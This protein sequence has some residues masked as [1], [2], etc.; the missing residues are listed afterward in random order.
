MI[1]CIPKIWNLKGKIKVE[2]VEENIFKFVF[3]EIREKEDV[4]RRRPWS[5]NGSLLI[6]KEWSSGLQLREIVFNTSTFTV[7]IHGLPP[8][9]FN[10]ENA[11]K[12]GNM[13]GL[14]YKESLRLDFYRSSSQ[15]IP[16]IPRKLIPLESARDV[17]PVMDGEQLI[18]SDRY[19]AQEI[20]NGRNE[21]M[22]EARDVISVNPTVAALS[23]T[24]SRQCA[25]GLNFNALLTKKG[26]DCNFN[27]EALTEWASN[28]IS[29]L[30]TFKAQEK[31][32]THQALSE[33]ENKESREV[34]YELVKWAGFG[35]G[36]QQEAS[37][38]KDH[39]S[40]IRTITQRKRPGQGLEDSSS[41]K[42]TFLKLTMPESE[43]DT[44][45]FEV[46]DLQSGFSSGRRTP[47]PIRTRSRR[48]QEEGRRGLQAKNLYEV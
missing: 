43:S 4:F 38:V 23:L 16:R 1:D 13:I 17:S 2:V 19:T 47:S 39:I 3:A 44:S 33:L 7:Q 26:R 27:Q 9:F 30:A 31:R 29:A 36:Y 10:L 32:K 22:E 28:F 24:L 6:L 20:D 48:R 34:G 21:E 37:G 42:E 12:I 45:R 8:R 15:F 41:K 11:E 35:P 14:L 40:P 18:K 46:E 25:E 5:F